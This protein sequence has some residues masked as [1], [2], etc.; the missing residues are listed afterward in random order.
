MKKILILLL[1]IPFL[2]LTTN[3]SITNQFIGKWAGEDKGDIGYINFD[4]DGY[5]S[6][7]I[8]GQV[9]GG[10]EFVMD[11]KKG[12]ITYKIDESTNPI[13]VDFV[14]TKLESGE[15][16]RLLCIARFKNENEMMFAINFGD[17]RPT[18]FNSENSITLKRENN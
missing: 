12:K 9:V 4:K 10:K 3:N 5:A 14:L 18:E 17:T 7:E 16:K 1:A 13:H 2:A 15:Q 11:G 6:F 8:K